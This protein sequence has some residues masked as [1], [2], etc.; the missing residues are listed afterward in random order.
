[1]AFVEV[2]HRHKIVQSFWTEAG[3]TQATVRQAVTEAER[4]GFTL[5]VTM[6]RENRAYLTSRRVEVPWSN[7]NLTVKWEHFVSK[8]G[9]A[10]KEP[11]TAVVTGP[12]AKRAVAEMVAPL[13]D[14]SLDAYLPHPWPQGFGV[15]RQDQS[16]LSLQF[17]NAL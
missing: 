7:K 2:E 1:R 13:Y 6:V 9:P 4:G 3:C 5:H 8:L 12:A 16:N 11:W 17:E 10:Q 14:Q 15:F